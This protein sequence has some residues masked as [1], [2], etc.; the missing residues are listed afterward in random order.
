MTR[1]TAPD[2][3]KRFETAFRRLAT[4]LPQ[5]PDA[6][7]GAGRS[8]LLS[9]LVHVVDGVVDLG[10][11][12][13][14]FLG[15]GADFGH[16]VRD[17][18]DA[19]GD[20]RKRRARFPHQFDA[21]LDLSAG[22]GDQGLDLA[23]RVGGPL[24]QGADL[25][26]H[27]RKAATSLARPGRLD[28]G[29]ERQKIGLEGDLVD[30]A[31]D[32]ADLGGGGLDLLHGGDGALNHGAAGLGL[33]AGLA[34]DRIGGLGVLGCPAHGG[35]DLV[36][37]GGGLFQSGGLTLGAARQVF[38]GAADLI[39]AVLH[40]GRIDAND[41]HR[42]IQ[43]GDRPVEV[44]AQNRVFAGEGVGDPV[45]QVAGRQGGQ[46][47]PGRLDHRGLNLGGE[48]VRLQTPLALG[49]DGGD[50]GG[51]LDHLARLSV[52]VEDRIVAG[53]DDHARAVLGVADEL[54]GD[55]FARIQPAPQVGVGGRIGVLR[56]DEDA[57]VGALHLVQAVAHHG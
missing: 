20:A 37:G 19:R 53:L 6:G 57:V 28:P 27:D 9:D 47:A 36:Q 21:G 1:R 56:I 7:E 18:V 51:E 5:R 41:R 17:V 4:R 52:D 14:L 30:D 34:H 13:G 46:G 35:G 50:V 49:L 24:G 22:G 12:N 48:T 29:I 43:G 40:G 8:I 16:Q 42:L 15:R 39:G 25:G 11:G 44:F 55:E 33:G 3:P 26:G 31:D 10:Q 2:S 32:L 23:G 38:G 54:V 45:G